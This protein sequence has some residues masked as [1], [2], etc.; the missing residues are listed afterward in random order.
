MDT[1]MRRG[2]T[3]KHMDHVALFGKPHAP[4]LQ[5]VGRDLLR[6]FTARNLRVSI[7][8]ESF[9]QIGDGSAARFSESIPA[10]CDLVIVL[11]G[12]GTLLRVARA[13]RR[14]DVPVMAVNMGSLG[15]LS[16]FTLNEMYDS[17]N[18]IMDG[19]FSV[20]RRLMLDA[21][22]IRGEEIV[23]RNS[24]LNDVVINKATLARIVQIAANVDR[25]PLTTFFSDGVIVSTPTGSTA[26]SLAAGG[27][28]IS[29]SLDAI[30]LTPIC[31]HTLTNRPIVMSAD[32]V[33]E[34]E[35]LSQDSE[36]TLTLD[37]QLWFPLEHL[38][39]VEIRRSPKS[40]S[41]IEN[42]NT[43]FYKVLCHKLKWG[44]R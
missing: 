24:V 18:R 29:P 7:E 20:S 28:I 13:L 14:F 33:I 42:P 25:K 11:G 6:F 41:L 38:D 43:S 21:A 31:P 5:E 4:K 23:H 26:Y 1:H 44:Q 19:D 16:A 10:D 8:A 37:G 36:V 27:P 35:L 3:E 30:V 12:D 34:F 40:I 15:F 9:D 39:R 2:L 22:Q 17:L 32:Q